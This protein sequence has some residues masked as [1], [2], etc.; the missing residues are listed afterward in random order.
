MNNIHGQRLN[1]DLLSAKGS[2]YEGNR[3]PDFCLTRDRWSQIINLQ[4]GPDGQMTMIDWYDANACHHREPDG[5]DRTNGRIFKISYQNAKPAHVDLQKMSDDELIELQLNPNDWYVRHARRILQERGPK[6]GG[7]RK[8]GRHDSRTSGRNAAAAGAVGPAR[9][10]RIGRNAGPDEFAERTSRTSA[11]GRFNWRVKIHATRYPPA[12][13][14]AFRALAANDLSPVVRLY[15]AS[16]LQRMPLDERWAILLGLLAHSEDAGDHNLPLMLW[17]AAEPLAEQNPERALAL[18]ADGKIPLV[19]AF[20]VRRIAKI[21]TPA[22]LDVLA[23]RLE[24]TTQ[25]DVQLAMLAAINEGLK[26]RRQ[27]PMPKA[28]M[29]ASAQLMQSPQCR[30]QRA[31]H[32]ARPDV[33][34]SRGV[35][36][37]ARRVGRRPCRATPSGERPSTRS[38]RSA[39]PN[40]RRPCNR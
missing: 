32:G 39:I 30:S 22:A 8:A 7:T 33:R 34:R 15:L 31:S 2:G 25:P 3:A 19:L 37:V 36:E 1:E 26:G 23:A 12:M 17:Y 10:R 20:M 29:A 4:Y 27:V 35:G 16:A 24:K 5:H 40:W 18:A 9:Q 11:L 21:G 28:W 13:L 38:L 6:A 14:E